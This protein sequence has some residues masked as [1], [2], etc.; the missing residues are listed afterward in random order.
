MVKICERIK[1]SIKER[2]WRIAGEVLLYTAGPVAIYNA[3][4]N[5]ANNTLLYHKMFML[6]AP[7]ATLAS[8]ILAVEY[9][10]YLEKQK[11]KPTCNITI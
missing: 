3:L 6:T 2:P 5:I 8:L 1:N 4:T 11:Y 10:H 9:G 7:F